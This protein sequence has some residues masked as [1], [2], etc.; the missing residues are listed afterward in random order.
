M[1][2]PA[3]ALPGWL[4]SQAPLA[5]ATAVTHTVSVEARGA[6]HRTC[7]LDVNRVIERSSAGPKASA[8][9]KHPAAWTASKPIPLPTYTPS[10]ARLWS[11]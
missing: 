10:W 5:S 4:A 8:N 9:T 7:S 2:A 6:I 1:R 3:V 11:L